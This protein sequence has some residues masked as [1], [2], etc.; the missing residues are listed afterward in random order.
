[1]DLV[2]VST[3]STLPKPRGFFAN[4]GWLSVSQVIQ[5]VLGLVTVIY[6][7]R[8]LHP[9]GY[10][11]LVWVG[12][13][14]TLISSLSS[15]GIQTYATRAIARNRQDATALVSEATA[16]SLAL[17]L[18]AWIV[19]LLVSQI[20]HLS[21]EAQNVLWILSSQYLIG[22]FTVPWA[23]AGMEHLQIPAIANVFGAATRL[24]VVILMVKNPTDL[25]S[26]AFATVASGLCIMGIEQALLKKFGVHIVWR[27]VNRVKMVTWIKVSLPLAALPLLYQL[28]YNFD[29]A[30]LGLYHGAVAVGYYNV[31]YRPVLVLFGFTALLTQSLFPLVSRVFE[32]NPRL[33]HAILH[34]VSMLI[35]ILAIPAGVVG[36]IFRARLL[37]TIFGPAYGPSIIPFVWLLW[38][39]VAAS[40][41]STV[42]EML[43]ALDKEKLYLRVFG[44]SVG[45]NVMLN[46]VTAYLWGD[47]GAAVTF[48]LTQLGMFLACEVLM[49][50]A[51]GYY[52]PSLKAALYVILLCLELNGLA[53]LLGHAAFW[54]V[55]SCVVANYAAGTWLIARRFRLFAF[56][57]YST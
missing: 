5:A 54:I 6:L 35:F 22:V 38:G 26:A 21:S 11:T 25:R 10:G 20:L 12:S 50:R 34:R 55:G 44:V 39:W 48:F 56:T 14:V 7:T 19:L 16:T 32:E 4:V 30:I 3:S 37:M 18:C 46:I 28:Y 49:V 33:L 2:D 13:I 45:M 52:G 27:R 8:T 41:N 57:E 29:S 15:G 42:G 23:Y 40:L 53:V 31:A 43:I 36:S 47:V 9:E 51:T 17:G 1:M 24:A